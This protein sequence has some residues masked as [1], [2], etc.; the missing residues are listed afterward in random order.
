MRLQMNTCVLLRRHKRLKYMQAVR[1]APTYRMWRGAF[2]S[3]ELW[4]LQL[5][6][7]RMIS[8]TKYD[9]FT[10]DLYIVGVVCGPSVP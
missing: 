8:L 3:F 5:I 6:K 1:A 7:K 10:G 9:S 4:S 2:F